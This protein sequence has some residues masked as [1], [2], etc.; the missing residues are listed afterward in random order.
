VG[1][2][3][4]VLKQEYVAGGLVA[5]APGGGNWFHKHFRVSKEPMRT[6]NY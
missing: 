3:D 4:Q 5:A 6:I 1:K 2:D